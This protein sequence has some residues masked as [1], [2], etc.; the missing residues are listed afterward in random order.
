MWNLSCTKRFAKDF[1]LY[2]LLSCLKKFC[3]FLVFV[4]YGKIITRCQ[5]AIELFY[6]L[7][8]IRMW[9][10]RERDRE[11][12]WVRG[13]SRNGDNPLVPLSSAIEKDKHCIHLSKVSQVS[14]PSLSSILLLLPLLPLFHLC[15]FSI[16]CMP[17]CVC[18]C[19]QFMNIEQINLALI[20]SSRGVAS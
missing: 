17:S 15:L 6:W 5:R 19:Q 20:V 3:F 4:Y 14:L 18:H 10:R 1:S 2:N 7:A 11:R 8:A 16:S 12:Q 9:G 13:S